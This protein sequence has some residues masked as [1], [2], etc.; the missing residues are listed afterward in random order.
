MKNTKYASLNIDWEVLKHS[1]QYVMSTYT[2]RIRGT[3][4]ILLPLRIREQFTFKILDSQKFQLW[5]NWY[6]NYNVIG[7]FNVKNCYTFFLTWIAFSWSCVA[8]CTATPVK[9]FPALDRRIQWNLGIR[10]TQGLRKSVLYSEVAL[11]LRSI[12][13]Y[14]IWL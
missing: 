3:P 13:T 1:T 10:D 14:W 7:Y 9:L 5:S 11:F 2:I 8:N 6:E 12:S 4:S